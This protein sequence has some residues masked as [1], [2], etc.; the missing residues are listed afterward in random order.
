RPRMPY[1]S[2]SSSAIQTPNSVSGEPETMENNNSTEYSQDESNNQSPIFGVPL[3]KSIE[4]ANV[5]ISLSDPQGEQ[6]IYGYIPIVVA[7]CGVY[8][9]QNA[10]TVEG[11]FRLS[12]S[13]KRIKDLQYIF[14]APPRFG[15]GLD[16]TGFNVHDA[17]NVLRR[18]LNNLPEPI[19]PLEFYEKFRDPLRDCTT[20]M[21]YLENKTAQQNPSFSQQSESDPSKSPSEHESDNYDFEYGIPEDSPLGR[22]ILRA[23][24]RYQVL[25]ANLPPLNRQL[26]MYI[27]DLLAVFASRSEENLMPAPNLAAIFQPSIL[28]HPTHDMSPSDYHLSRAVIEFMIEHSN[29]FL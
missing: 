16:W 6:F 22:D 29:K 20:I 26:L 15:K 2:R 11:I 25:I 19:I 12:G 21:A 23:V 8:L 5:S 7:K 10:T 1:K 17:A 24:D 14:N 4:Y 13:A 27:L 3:A 9:K 28:S 18:Y